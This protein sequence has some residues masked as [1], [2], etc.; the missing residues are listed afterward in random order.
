MKYKHHT[1]DEGISGVQLDDSHFVGWDL[2][3][4]SDCCNEHMNLIAAA[5][6]LL[7]ACQ[8][9]VAI[10]RATNQ[11]E[12]LDVAYRMAEQAIEKATGNLEDER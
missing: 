4:W 3:G 9:F 11:T 6:D 8:K 2:E 10:R 1:T 7:A 12:K 5:P